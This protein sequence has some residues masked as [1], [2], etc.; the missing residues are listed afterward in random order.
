MGNIWL[1]DKSCTLNNFANCNAQ[2]IAD[3]NKYAGD[4][5]HDYQRTTKWSRN[6]EGGFVESCLEHVAAQG[7]SFN[8]YKIRGKPMQEALSAWWHASSN[9][10]ASAQ[11]FLP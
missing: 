2:Q 4:L 7:A 10:A 1:G 3:L 5:V 9:E 6:G 8:R 11:W